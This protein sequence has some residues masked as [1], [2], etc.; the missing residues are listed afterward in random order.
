MDNVEVAL[1]KSIP[2]TGVG[3]KELLDHLTELKKGDADYKNGKTFS[4]VY[5][6]SDEFDKF[7]AK[8]YNSFLFENYLNPMAFKS[9][10]QME[11]EVVRMAAN[12]F[13]GNDKTVGVMT[14]GGTESILLACKSYRDRAR[15]KKPWIRT[16]EMLVSESVHVAF[17]KASK[18]FDLKFVRIPM[19]DDYRVDV[20]ALK[21]KINRNTVMI[22][23]S[24]PQYPQGVI[25][26]IEEVGAIALKKGIPLH[27]DSCIGGFF[28]PF[29][30]KIGR[31]VPL[32]D[33]RVPGVTSISADI[34][35]FGYAPKGSSV[36]M[37]RD[38][39]YMK[40]QFFVST[41]WTGGIYASPCLP[42]SRPGGAISSA[43]AALHALGEDG[44]CDLVKKAMVVTDKYIEGLKK[45]PHVKVLG[46]PDMSLVAWTT[47]GVDLYAVADHLQSKGW[48]VDRQQKPPS[49]HVTLTS[50]HE[51]IIDQWLEDIADSVEYVK[52]H[53]ELES[54]GQAAMYGMM[55]KVPFKGLVKMSVMK[56]L[57]G[58]YGPTG[59]IPDLADPNA[60]GD[61]GIFGV[62]NKY[63]PKA[64]DVVKKIDDSTKE[65]RKSIRLPFKK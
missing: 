9:L 53:P 41:N 5:H 44:F 51:K 16:P 17:D 10:K 8:A 47:E 23:V 34:H 4:L 55:A 50:N 25:D 22:A 38:M 19:R 32:F 36:L 18:Y 59:K 30:E 49:V 65:V 45:I 13:N 54:Q 46:Q 7:M 2:E 64:M 42:G 24:A 3:H 63:G 20:K 27:V 28:L 40:H 43:W 14:S 52:N 62:V 1:D 60:T 15:K 11:V 33:F 35:K 21:K 29:M 48:M 39:E 31:K 12:M 58:M 57:E 37:Y 26:P 6:I 56:L 61:D